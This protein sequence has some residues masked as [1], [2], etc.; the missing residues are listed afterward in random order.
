[1]RRIRVGLAMLCIATV[2]MPSLANHTHDGTWSYHH[3]HPIRTGN[4]E[5]GIAAANS[6]GNA[7]LNALLNAEDRPDW[8]RRTDL[9]YNIQRRFTPVWGIET[10]QPLFEDCWNTIFWQ[11]R[12]AYNSGDGTANLGLGWRY[13]NDSRSLMYGLNFFYDQTYRY[14]HKRVGVG[15]ELFT[16]LITL[17][18]N[19]YDAISRTKHVGTTGTGITQYER[20]LSGFDGSIETPVPYVPWIR[21][22]AQGYHWQ[23]D[24][25]ADINGGQA[26]LRIFPARQVEVDA[27]VADDNRNHWQGFLGINYYLAPA[28]FIEQSAMTSCPTCPI[29]AQNL[30][31][32]RLEKVLR[33]N[34][35]IVEKTSSA[36]VTNNSVVIARG[37]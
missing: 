35:I 1:M 17:R 11:G 28:C 34:N 25:K 13:L 5:D 31:N 37:D 24:K 7:Y 30:E 33:Q 16:P 23:G 18:A 36:N 19:Y 3:S 8:L 27:G 20:A 10:I 6:F 21:F 4:Y 22:M 9:T 2:A 14:I 26:S 29:V 12:A 32:M 15:G